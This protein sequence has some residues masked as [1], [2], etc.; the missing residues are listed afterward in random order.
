[1]YYVICEF[2]ILLAFSCS[3]ITFGMGQE[4]LG[5][6]PFLSRKEVTNRLRKFRKPKS[7]VAG[8]IFP[9]LVNRAAASLAFPL[10]H[11]YNSVSISHVWPDLWKIEYVTPIPK[12]NVPQSAGDLRNI[13]CTQLFSKVYETFILEW[14]TGQVVLRDNQFGGVKGRSTEHFLV[15]LWQRVLENIEDSRAGSLLTSIDYSKAFN[16]LDFGHCIKCLKAKGANGKL[17]RIIASFLSGRVMKVKVGTSLSTA[18]AVL[19]GV[20]Q[21]S[22]LGVFLFNLAIDDFEAFSPDVMDY[23]REGQ[24]MTVPA[25]GHPPDAPVPPEPT[26]RDR[27]HV[28]PFITELIQVLKYVDDNV[29]NEKVNFDTVPTDGYGFRTKQAVRTQ[30]VFVRT[31]FQAEAVKMQVNASKTK[32]MLISEIKSY[33]PNAF[34]LDNNGN[35]VDTSNNMKILGVNFS[36]DP[37]MSA[38]VESIK[39][40]FR[41]R[42]WILHHLGHRG[43]SQAEL[44]SVFRSTILPVHDYCSCV[45]NSSLTLSQASALERLQ[46]QALKAIYGYEHSYRALLEKSGLKTL[47]QRRDE[48]GEKFAKKCLQSDRFKAWF[49]LNPVSR[50]T[51]NPL[52]YKEERTKTKR[53]YN[54]PIYQMRRVLNGRK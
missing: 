21:G 5:Y 4:E 22:I 52:P 30:N 27:R 7:M 54:S 10:A 46:S 38:H 44:L 43:F 28:P 19:G 34:F 24:P 37:D 35:R 8:D 1:M 2:S 32:S 3:Q 13:S 47:Q 17:I 31:V 20:P 23:A 6:L 18:R 49:P 36:S 53:L 41:S 9:A 25:P 50:V 11:I 14:V 48:R 29:I 12:K 40:A 42:K 51:R 39:Q 33:N 26:G 16:R 15:E 45:F